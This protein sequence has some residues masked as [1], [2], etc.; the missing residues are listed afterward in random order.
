MDYTVM[1]VQKWHWKIQENESGKL[2]IKFQEND[3]ILCENLH[4]H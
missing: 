1:E 3:I 4:T 2:T